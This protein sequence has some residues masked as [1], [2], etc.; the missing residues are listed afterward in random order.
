MPP[1]QTQW[2]SQADA[3]ALGEAA[4][5]ACALAVL[6]LRRRGD[7]PQLPPP[8]GEVQAM[9]DAANQMQ[10]ATQKLIVP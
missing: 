8:P 1:I 2:P 4:T 9:M 3:E 5:A 6:L 10:Q 7:S